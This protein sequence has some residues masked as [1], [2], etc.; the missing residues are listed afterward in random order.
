MREINTNQHGQHFVLKM[1]APKSA[2]SKIIGTKGGHAKEIAQRTGCRISISKRIEGIQE[3]LVTLKI[4][5][6]PAVSHVPSQVLEEDGLIDGLIE[7]AKLIVEMMQDDPHLP[8]HLSCEMDWIQSI[9]GLWMLQRE[10]ASQLPK[11]AIV[12]NLQK[13]APREILIQHRLLGS[14]KKTLKAKTHEQVLRFIRRHLHLASA[15]DSAM[16]AGSVAQLWQVMPQLREDVLWPCL[17]DIAQG[18]RFKSEDFNCQDLASVAQAF[19]KLER[20]NDVFATVLDRCF[21]MARAADRDLCYLLWAAATVPRWADSLFVGRAVLELGARDAAKM[22][23]KDL[24]VLL[25]SLGKLLRLGVQRKALRW[26]LQVLFLEGVRRSQNF[27][28]KDLACLERAR[29]ALEEDEAPAG[30]GGYSPSPS[31]PQAPP[32]IEF[33]GIIPKEPSLGH[34]SEEA[35]V[36][37]CHHGHCH[38]HDGHNGHDGHDGHGFDGHGHS[39]CTAAISHGDAHGHQHGECEGTFEHSTSLKEAPSCENETCCRSLREILRTFDTPLGFH[40]AE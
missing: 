7:A 6:Q 24:M 36:P 31:P 30:S 40:Q 35:W 32:G 18:A 23:S 3:R 21:C 12:E 17:E 14:M 22:A 10:E 8:E 20:P 33:I 13:A 37:G 28:T 25:Q 29:E 19:A 15:R 9:S 27:G 2:V 5:L 26:Q 1:P 34:E 4:V 11:R 39:T 16:V 38:S